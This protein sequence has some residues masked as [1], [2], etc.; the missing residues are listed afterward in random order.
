VFPSDPILFPSSHSEKSR[1]P[2]DFGRHVRKN[3]ADIH[4]VEFFHGRLRDFFGQN[5]Q[6]RLFYMYTCNNYTKTVYKRIERTFCDSYIKK[7]NGFNGMRCQKKRAKLQLHGFLRHA[8]Q[9]LRM[10]SLPPAA[11]PV[12]GMLLF[13]Q[14]GKN[15]RQEHF[16]PPERQEIG[17]AAFGGANHRKNP[18][19]STGKKDTSGRIHPQRA[20]LQIKPE[21]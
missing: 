8:R 11:R 21:S 6:K 12:P 19:L 16:R 5:V 1:I 14:G 10:R 9:M 4:C 20:H 15:V 3:D 18:V 17:A 7:E 13:G 2:G